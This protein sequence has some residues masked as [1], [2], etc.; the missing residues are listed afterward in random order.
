MGNDPNRR[1]F[2]VGAAAVA[3]APMVSASVAQ[4]TTEGGADLAY[5]SAKEL[6][7]LLAQKKVSSVEL[8]EH[9]IKRIE[10]FDP[11]INVV[12]VRDFDRAHDAAKAAD[13]ALARG[14]RQPLLGIPMTVKEQY[15]VAGLPTTWGIPGFKDW[16]PTE[17]SV[18]VARLKA[19]GAV[20]LGKTNVPVILGDWQSFN[21]IYGTTNNPWDVARTSGGSTGGAAGLAAGYVSLEMGSDLG[22]S[23]RIPAHFCGVCGHKPSRNLIP[24]RGTQYPKDELPSFLDM[25]VLGPLARTPGDLSLVLDVVSGPDESE[26][27]GYRLAL[28]PARHDNLKSFRV[29]VIDTHPLVPTSSPVRASLERLSDQL[30]KAGAKVAHRSLSLPDLAEQAR[31]YARL[32]LGVAS[33]KW[34]ADFYNTTAKAAS[35]LSPSDDSLWA[36][37]L[38]GATM[39]YRDWFDTDQHRVRLLRQWR[40]LFR[41]WDVVLCPPAS[42]PA[43]PHDHNPDF[44]ARRIEVDG[45]SVDYVDL[46]LAWSGVA[47]LPDL[48]ATVVPLQRSETGLPIGVQIIGPHLEDRTTIAFAGLVEREF[49]G[50][51]PPPGY[52]G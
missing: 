34:P 36:A 50:F 30:T 6:S 7:A 2:L 38:R 12:V 29:L 13:E 27:I 19:A 4:T 44:T 23:I 52:R 17:D 14:E 3:A 10:T 37:R 9:S 51:V 40:E 20:I 33:A 25:A 22:G 46:L 31:V 39:S 5:R 8:L 15:N 48:P 49:G 21:D 28:P 43:F 32:V 18:A 42:V 24:G 45:Q 41:E 26:A 16:K 35:A 47:N 1:A 11:R